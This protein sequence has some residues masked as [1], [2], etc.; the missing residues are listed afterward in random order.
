MAMNG[1]FRFCYGLGPAKKAGHSLAEVFPDFEGELEKANLGVR[2]EVYFSMLV[3]TTIFGILGAHLVGAF[4]GF[5][6]LPMVIPANFAIPVFVISWVVTFGLGELISV[7]TLVGLYFFPSYQ[8]GERTKS[9]DR[10]IGYC[11]NYMSAMASADVTPSDIFKGLS[12]QE[13]Y[14]EIQT[15][16]AMIARDIDIFGKDLVKVLQRAMSRTPSKRFQDFLQGIITTSNSGGSLK[17]YFMAKS[18]EYRKETRLD[19]KQNLQTLGVMAESFV[20]VVVASP[21]FLVVMM[22][23]MAMMGNESSMLLLWLVVLVMIPLAQFGFLVLMS[24]NPMD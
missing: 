17:A 19:Q 20:T 3:V 16:S 7:I 15:E 13:L 2:A 22:S 12:R 14:G 10:N 18:E 23:V 5:G 8:K 1:Y 4:I 21:L 24:G 11:V 9:I 6:M